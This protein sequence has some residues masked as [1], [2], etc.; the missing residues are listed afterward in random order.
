VLLVPNPRR[1]RAEQLLMSANVQC[2]WSGPPAADEI[3]ARDQERLLADPILTER[4]SGEDAILARRLLEGRS[5]EDIAAALIRMHR[6]RLPAPAELFDS[7]PQGEVARAHATRAERDDRPAKVRVEGATAWFR[8]SIGR[9][10]NADPKWLLP[11]I[12]RVGE[13]TRSDIGAI[14]VFDRET[15]FEIAEE[16]AGRF[17]A[18]VDRATDLE[19][20]ISPAGAAPPPRDFTPRG[21]GPRDGAPRPA[22][23][24]KFN[25]KK[26]G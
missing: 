22:G 17:A 12:C 13:V 10:A 5:A 16:A 2:S 14:R 7:Q 15:K 4:A 11:L 9:Q 8:I 6:A 26:A 21:H 25:R 24:R 23:P 20:Q 18:A 3:R 19:F 1:R